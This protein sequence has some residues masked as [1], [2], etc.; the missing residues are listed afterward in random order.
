MEQSLVEI[1]ARLLVAV[2]VERHEVPDEFGA[3]QVEAHGE[4]PLLLLGR[5]VQEPRLPLGDRGVDASR[6]LGERDRVADIVVDVAGDLDLVRVRLIRPVPEDD[7]P[8][9][10]VRKDALADDR[11][12][13]DPKRR[14]RHAVE[15][16]DGLLAPL[17]LGD[18]ELVDVLVVVLAEKP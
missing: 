11:L 2:P 16:H 10:F 1:P 13:N 4:Q 14:E 7:P 9:V 15:R 3:Q 17:V 18:A 8:P 12:P 6:Q 5:F